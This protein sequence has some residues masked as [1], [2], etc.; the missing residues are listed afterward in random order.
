MEQDSELDEVVARLYEAGVGLDDVSWGQALRGV[1]RVL[2]AHTV[3][4]L[5]IDLAQRSLLFF[6][7]AGDAPPEALLD[8][9]R[10]YHLIDPRLARLLPMAA[11]RWAHCHEVFDDAF[12]A[13]D[14]FY[15]EFLLPYGGRWSS[16]IKLMEE[17]GV[18]VMFAV[19]RRR[20]RGPMAGDDLVLCDRLSWHVAKAFRLTERHRPSDDGT[21]VI[22]AAMNQLGVP[23]FLLD[24]DC[25]IRF[26]N[27]SARSLMSAGGALYELD[28]R[29][30]LRQ[31]D[32]DR[33]F[34]ALG[35]SLYGKAGDDRFPASAYLA[36][37]AS[38]HEGVALPERRHVDGIML[39]SLM[40]ERTIGAFGESPALLAVAHEQRGM[41]EPDP[42]VVASAFCLTR[43]EARIAIA[44]ALGLSVEQIAERRC[45]A[46]ST[47][48]SQ[49]KSM[50][51]KMG[52]TRQSEVVSRVLSLPFIF[53]GMRCR[54]G[55]ALGPSRMV[56]DA[57]IHAGRAVGR[58]GHDAPDSG[59]TRGVGA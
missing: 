19:T 8:Y 25:R 34:R 50:L 48:R 28:G 18:A 13:N 59:S 32:N 1:Q 33:A 15:Q 7:E 56:R 41:S 22:S 55:A 39:S 58:R 2:H 53:L 26:S 36:L 47:V 44:F 12:V 9:T 49:V 37:T 40:P 29:L 16:G 3:T 42:A 23:V 21:G 57:D 20:E 31:A 6:A 43:A 14:P 45:K 10:S 17:G 24:G 30:A 38:G 46:V 27:S 11:G 5:S 51:A 35:K 52:C 4:L 54:R